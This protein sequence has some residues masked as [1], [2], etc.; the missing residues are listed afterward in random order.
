MLILITMMERNEATQKES[1]VVSHGVDER[2]GKNVCLPGE[3]PS[4]LGGVYCNEMREWVIYDY[5]PEQA[6]QP[7]P[8]PAR[9]VAREPHEDWFAQ[10]YESPSM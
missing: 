8:A 4:A 3:H 6:E 1:L 5:T 9:K 2:T 10:E 7:Q